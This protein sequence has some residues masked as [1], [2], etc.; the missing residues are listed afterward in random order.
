MSVAVASSITTTTVGVVPQNGVESSFLSKDV[1]VLGSTQWS[2]VEGKEFEDLS[3]SVVKDPSELKDGDVVDFDSLKVPDVSSVEEKKSTMEWRGGHKAENN[4]FSTGKVPVDKPATRYSQR[5]QVDSQHVNPVADPESLVRSWIDSEHDSYL[6]NVKNDL[7]ERLLNSLKKSKYSV[8]WRASEIINHLTEKSRQ[9]FRVVVD[10]A[11]TKSGR[12]LRLWEWKFGK[13]LVWVYAASPVP[14]A[15]SDWQSERNDVLASI[16]ENNLVENEETGDLVISKKGYSIMRRHA[17]RDLC[18][19]FMTLRLFTDFLSAKSFVI[20]SASG[21]YVTFIKKEKPAS[22][23]RP[24][25]GE[26]LDTC[27]AQT[28]ATDGEVV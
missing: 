25:N 11:D 20:N 23:D 24:S 27:V 1:S 7:F 15:T 21:G 22:Y 9:H 26:R 2:D 16:Y 4:R 5:G 18:M 12:L 3:S 14:T 6:W 19:E 13:D 8:T 17:T 28:G 10:H